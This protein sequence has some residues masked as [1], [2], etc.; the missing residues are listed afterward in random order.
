MTSAASGVREA[1]V[2]DQH[3]HGPVLDAELPERVIE[4][5]D[6]WRYVRPRRAP[7]VHRTPAAGGCRG[8]VVRGALQRCRR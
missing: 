8:D 3:D 2:V 6:V 5:L 7:R 1:D 4:L